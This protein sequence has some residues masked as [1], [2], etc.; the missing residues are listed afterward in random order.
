MDALHNEKSAKEWIGL[1]K[2]AVEAGMLYLLLT[3]GEIFLRKDF[4]TIYEEI[5]QMGIIKSIYSN[6]TL[7]TPEIA[8][9]LG[10]IPP[11]QIDITLYGASRDTYARVC[12]D[13][14]GFDRAINGIDLLISEGINVQ[15]R[16]TVIK[17]N[18]DDYDRL[19]EIAGMRGID[20][21]IVDY[22]SPRR[23][24]C[25]TCPEVERLSPVE[26]VTYEKHIF[27]GMR[28][29]NNATKANNCIEKVDVEELS[30]YHRKSNDEY[31]FQCDNGQNSFWVTWDGKMIPCSLLDEP[32]SLPFQ[33]GFT[34][35]WKGLAEACRTVPVCGTC[36]KCTLQDF[37]I[38]CPA[39]L[40]SETGSFRQPAPYLCELAQERYKEYRATIV[41]E[42]S[43]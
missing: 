5:S 17:S 31:P 8:K 42:V 11:S 29:R 33:Q 13:A 36:K 6:G 26:L 14:N 38:S 39:R 27:D 10:R 18:K 23:E 40:K 32:Y 9:W 37:C 16:T 12:G 7:I 20:L 24:G 15:I 28:N 2:E 19:E 1:A 3:G 35:S 21:R 41:K 43:I 34:A 25:L 30:T 4:Q 22:V